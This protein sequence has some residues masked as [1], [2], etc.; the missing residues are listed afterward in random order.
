[1]CRLQYVQKW[2]PIPIHKNPEDLKYGDKEMEQLKNYTAKETYQKNSQKEEL[3]TI[4][5][6][7]K[8]YI[9]GDGTMAQFNWRP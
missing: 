1:M 2:R 6:D 8:E 5:K 3:E 9:K 4:I 7:S